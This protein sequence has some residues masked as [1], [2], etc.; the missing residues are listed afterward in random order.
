MKNKT[1]LSITEAINLSGVSR[2]Q[3]YSKY[4]NKGRISKLRDENNK[5]YIDSSELFRVFP[6]SVIDDANTDCCPKLKILEQQYI[7]IKQENTYLK[8]QLEHYKLL[9][10]RGYEREIGLQSTIKHYQRSL[11]NPDTEQKKDKKKQKK[12]K[13]KK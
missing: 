5:V 4:I 11:P 7:L 12:T 2:S 8:E 6:N 1:R 10:K 9:E 13:K 3:F